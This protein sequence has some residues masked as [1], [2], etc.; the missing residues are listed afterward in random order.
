V[1]R[2][3]SG[4]AGGASREMGLATQVFQIAIALGG[5]TLVMKKRWLW[6]ASLLCGALAMFQMAKVLFMG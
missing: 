2:D 4:I 6:Y 5:I 3:A 1:A